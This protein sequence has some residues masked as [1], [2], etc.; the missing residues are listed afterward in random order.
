MHIVVY[1]FMFIHTLVHSWAGMLI[2]YHTHT[3]T[4]THTI[5]LWSCFYP[6]SP[7]LS[8]FIF[9]IPMFHVL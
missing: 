8:L 1:Q 5:M 2:N 3:H 7:P 9:L 4:H 6:F